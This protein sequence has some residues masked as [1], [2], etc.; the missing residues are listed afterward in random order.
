MKNHPKKIS[1][2]LVPVLLLAVGNLWASPADLDQAVRKYNAGHPDQAIAILK[3]LAIKGDIQAQ[4]LLGNIVY[5]LASA[6]PSSTSEDPLKWYR[7]AAAQGS[8]EA[9][10][11]VGVIHN[12]IWL[13]TRREED[14]LLAEFY[15]QQAL[16]RGYSKAEGPL[17]KIAAHNQANRQSNS[18]KY[19]NSSFNSI[20]QPLA[21]PQENPVNAPSQDAFDEFE[22][23]GD[24]IADSIRLEALLRQLNG[25]QAPI[26]MTSTG[27][28]WPDETTLI[29]MLTN[30]GASDSLASNLAKLLGQIKP[31]NQQDLSTG[32]N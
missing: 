15:Y 23:S 21:K 10:Y 29:R 13:K 19:S 30:F 5:G 26:G 17:M 14:S 7:M 20:Q 1:I 12:N 11:A 3:P 31:L 28:D 9:S 8:P 32:S 27:A 6:D 22:L 2:Y 16:D 24:A 25:G 4:N 18:R